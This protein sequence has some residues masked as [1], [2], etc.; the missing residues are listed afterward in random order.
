MDGLEG[1]REAQRIDSDW[2]VSSTVRSNFEHARI[3]DGRIRPRFNAPNT[4]DNGFKCVIN[5]EG[6]A[7][8]VFAQLEVSRE[9][10]RQTTLVNGGSDSGYA[11]LRGTKNGPIVAGSN[12]KAADSGQ[13]CPRTTRDNSKRARLKTGSATPGR[14]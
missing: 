4:N 7:N 13:A 9:N 2:I 3:L 10:V 14:T 6:G 12:D 1:F 8:S 5:L 11:R